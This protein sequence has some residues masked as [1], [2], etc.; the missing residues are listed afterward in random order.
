MVAEAVAG[1]DFDY[2][3]V[4]MQH[5]LADYPAMV[6]MLQAISTTECTPVVRVPWNEPGIIGRVLDAGAMGVVIPM[7][8][9]VAEAHAAVA[10]CR[11]HPDGAR[12]FGPLRASLYG[13]PDYFTHANREV[14]C[15][16]M[17]ETREAIGCLE[18]ILEVTG[19]DAVYV[20]PADLAVTYGLPPG[21]GQPRSGLP[22]SAGHGRAGLPCPG[23]RTRHPLERR[24]R[25]HPA[26]AGLPDGDRHR[27]LRGRRGRCATR[28]RPGQGCA[29]RRHR[30][31]CTESIAGGC[32][33]GPIRRPAPWRSHGRPAPP[34]QPVGRAY[35]GAR[36]WT[37]WEPHGRTTWLSGASCRCPPPTRRCPAGT[38]PSPCPRPTSSTATRCSRRSPRASRRRS[39]AWAASGARSGSSG[40][41]P[42]CAPPPSATPAASPR[43]PPTRRCARGCTGHAEVVLVVFDPPV[44]ATSTLLKVFW[45][46]HDPTQGMRQGNDVGTQYRSAIYTTDDRPAG[47]GRGQSGPLPG[48]ADHGRLRR[49]HHRDRPA[50]TFYYAED[51]HQQYLAKVPN[52]YCGLGGTG[53]S[54]PVGLVAPTDRTDP[55]RAP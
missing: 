33:P 16:P 4:D 36:R 23:D 26:D 35:A 15:I 21:R 37:A 54:C 28:P 39:S 3:C 12:S 18:Q 24:R 9:S 52:G 5:G 47:G 32:A 41:R 10:A 7:V 14:A 20:G 25:R 51:Y 8:N 45:E 48:G 27:R 50:P 2:C 42:A 30:A 38:T 40:R 1:C 53:V 49:D 17:I 11:Y 55:S 29:G 19:I 6:R 34:V 44:T 46:G 13:G 31:A 22:G 43:T